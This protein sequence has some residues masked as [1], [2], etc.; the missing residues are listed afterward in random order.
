MVAPEDTIAEIGRI[1][2]MKRVVGLVWSGTDDPPTKG[3][4][5][6]DA[7]RFVVRLYA[8]DSESEAR[9]HTEMIARLEDAGLRAE[10][11]VP[12][13]DSAAYARIHALGFVTVHPKYAEIAM[14]QPCMPEDAAAWG[15]F[16]A[17]MHVTCEL[18]RPSC[19]VP[20]SSMRDPPADLLGEATELATVD[21]RSLEVIK[22]FSDVIVGTCERLRKAEATQPVH[23]DL[24]PGNLLKSAQGL[25]AIDFREAGNGSRA[26]DMATAFRW[27]PWE[28][29]R[30]KAE[31]LWR[32]WLSG[33]RREREPSEAELA[34]VAS[35]AC[36]Q[37]LWWLVQE[38]RAASAGAKGYAQSAWYVRDHCQAIERLLRPTGGEHAR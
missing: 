37:H 15:A 26:V 2:G 38:A 35:L 10:S 1:Y 11:V 16:V 25:R 13:V 23:G 17:A 21:V 32:A 28:E 3:K 31:L 27:L 29:N 36:L 33:Y 7:R 18:W 5:L 34:S 20:V 22:R 30:Q 12:T 9:Y 19:A 24:W 8:L 6:A 4:L 14:P